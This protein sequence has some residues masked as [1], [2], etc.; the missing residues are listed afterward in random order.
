M[1]N[2]SAVINFTAIFW[3][4]IRSIQTDDIL[5]PRVL[6]GKLRYSSRL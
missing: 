2:S 4:A 5:T 3:A 6:R 1:W